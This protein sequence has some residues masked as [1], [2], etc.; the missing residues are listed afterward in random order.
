MSFPNVS[1]TCGFHHATT[2]LF[3]FGS[4]QSY[5][6]FQQILQHRFSHQNL[7]TPFWFVGTQPPTKKWMDFHWGKLIHNSLATQTPWDNLTTPT[8]LLYLLVIYLL[9]SGL[10]KT[11][12][13]LSGP[14]FLHKPALAWCSQHAKSLRYPHFGEMY[15]NDNF[16]G[17]PWISIIICESFGSV[18][19]D[20]HNIIYIYIY[21]P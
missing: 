16:E 1:N 12:R 9:L 13:R 11:P 3:G 10:K 14:L 7:G 2:K 18:N 5:R 17:F 20:T 19:V 4:K 21:L 8:Q 15:D 6:W